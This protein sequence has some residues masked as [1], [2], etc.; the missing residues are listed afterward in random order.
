MFSEFKL[1]ILLLVCVFILSSALAIKIKDPLRVF[2]LFWL[3]FP[4]LATGVI[5]ILGIPMFT[6]LEIWIGFWLLIIVWMLSDEIFFYYKPDFTFR[7]FRKNEKYLIILLLLTLLIQYF[8]STW[9]SSGILSQ[10]DNAFTGAILIKNIAPEFVGLIFFYSCY[11]LIFTP[12]Q[13]VKLL[14]I[15]AIF[16]GLLF[17]EYIYILSNLPFSATLKSFSMNQYN[18][19]NSV[20]LNDYNILGLACGV[21]G[22]VSLYKIKFKGNGLW[23]LMFLISSYLVVVNL[24]RGVIV[25]Y[26]FATLILFYLGWFRYWKIRKKLLVIIVFP[27]SIIFLVSLINIDIFLNL[28]GSDYV[29]G[30]ILNAASGE[31]LG[32]RYGIQLKTIE[33]LSSVWPLGFGNDLGQYFL[34]GIHEKLFDVVGGSVSEGYYRSISSNTHNLYLEQI[35]SYGLLGLIFGLATI[36][37]V[38]SNLFNV[39]IYFRS[40]SPDSMFYALIVSLVIFI[41]IFYIFLAYPRAYVIVFL[42]IH[43]TAIL[44]YKIKKDKFD[45]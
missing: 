16:P 40:D 45:N 31:S 37:F 35:V 1:V 2:I 29:I 33:A 13:I 21:G 24:K 4:N 42:I 5:G 17:L 7:F 25:S 39:R 28:V 34:T 12:H 10:P 32:V 23:F 14:T 19:F 9:V 26:S 43:A 30:R 22:L 27:P 18:N 20:F 38:V 3:L 6:Y 8:F 15:F 36:T 44:N 11:R 41:A